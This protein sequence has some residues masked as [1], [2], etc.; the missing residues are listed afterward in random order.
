LRGIFFSLALVCGGQNAL[1]V[2][3]P[4]VLARGGLVVSDHYLASRVGASLLKQGGNA[5]DAAVGVGFALAV[6]HPCCGNIGGGGFMQI[7][8]HEAQP[9][10]QDWIVDFRETAP[11]AIKRT[12]FFDH[13]K[14]KS[15]DELGYLYVG[16]PG[17]VLGLI[18]AQQRFGHLP[19]KTVMEPAIQLAEQGFVLNRFDLAN[20]YKAGDA[21]KAQ[22]NVAKIMRP[23]GRW[24]RPGERWR[25]TDLAASLRKIRDQGSE[26]FYHG[27]LA[28][29]MVAASAAD[30]GVLSL[31]DFAAYQVH[32]RKPI[33]CDYHGYVLLTAPPPASGVTV[34]EILRLLNPLD[35]KSL[36]FH[37]APATHYNAA[38]MKQAFY[39]RNHL[40]G[41]PDFVNNPVSWLLSDAHLRPVQV[42]M[43][44]FK[45]VQPKRVVNKT[46]SLHTTHFVVM[47]RDHNVINTTYTINAYFGSVRIAGDTGFFLNND[48]K[49]FTLKTNQP[50]LFFLVQGDNNLIQGGKRPLS[51][52]SPTLVLK[53]G[54]VVMALGAAGG[55]T[56]ISSIVQAIENVI[57]Y[58]MDI[59]AAVDAPRY[60][61]QWQPNVIYQEPFTFS[62]DSLLRLKAMGYRVQENLFDRYPYWGQMAAIKCDRRG[63][64]AGSSDDR[65]PN[66][67]AIGVERVH[68]S[69]SAANAL[70]WLQ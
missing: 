66:G 42:M 4:P 27:E 2:Y 14:L 5:M 36:G 9:D 25:Q 8:W 26:V 21:I 10:A 62:N 65:H 37:S 31:A 68:L 20:F 35:L 48:L 67:R 23:A 3:A 69:K 44:K 54:R 34:C 39:D 22:T 18:E 51:S 59:H 6:V 28:Q 11:S 33:Q 53:K 40:L 50:N 64:M 12:E 32:W 13:G 41:D 7:H 16:V 52:M 63:V 38:A 58:G 47:D 19:L 30:H 45:N 61:M 55:P 57:D 60:H 15:D 46:P 56:I 17:T 70:A 24:P 49:D 43:A 1:A 29:K